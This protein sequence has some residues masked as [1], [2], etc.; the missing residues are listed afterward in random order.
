[1]STTSLSVS[2]TPGKAHSFLPKDTAPIQ[3]GVLTRLSVGGYPGRRSTF[4]AKDPAPIPPV[5]QTPDKLADPGGKKYREP[6]DYGYYVWKYGKPG[7]KVESVE[8]VD[9]EIDAEQSQAISQDL[10]DRSLELND[11]LARIEVE[12]FN[13]L[14]AKGDT[15][16]ATNF[17]SEQV[18]LLKQL[19]QHLLEVKKAKNNEL[20]I[21]L[22]II[23][24]FF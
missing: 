3:K 5:D 11:D 7:Q 21:I 19:R 18:E 14:Q 17:I 22:A 4:L 23:E 10:Q 6:F 12:L 16:Q 1:M 20:A 15:L 2:A 13:Y 24:Y 9:I 8:A